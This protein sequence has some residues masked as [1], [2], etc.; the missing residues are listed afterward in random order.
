MRKGFVQFVAVAATALMAAG[1]NAQ[2]PPTARLDFAV[3]PPAPTPAVTADYVAPAHE[4]PPII[5][6]NAGMPTGTCTSCGLPRRH[7]L[8]PLPYSDE[9]GGN[10]YPGGMCCRCEAEG[11][12]AGLYCHFYN[13]FQ[14]PDPCY[15]PHWEAGANA[16]LFVDTVR[17]ATSIRLR[18]DRGINMILPDRS[19]F[20]WARIGTIKGPPLPETSVDYH[21]LSIYI[22]TAAER[23][24]AYTVIPYRS[25]VGE[26]NGGGAGFGDM[27]IGTKTLL[28]DTEYAQLTLQF[29][30]FIPQGKSTRG[31]GTG[32][33]SLEPSLLLSARLTPDT[34]FQGQ[35]AEWIPLGGDPEGSGAV[36]HYHMALNHVIARPLAD[37]QFIA[38]LEAQGYCFQDGTFTDPV[39]GAAVRSSGGQYWSVGPGFR[40]VLSERCDFGFGVMFAVTREHFANQ[41]YRSEFRLRF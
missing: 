6:V 34:Y 9:C 29:Q 12:L 26:V 31:L 27:I 8:P 1:T 19:E 14:C 18:W 11:G 39:T 5:P 35:I 21:E 7:E 30:T 40:W 22:E 15:E 25:V 20:F 23:F 37:S 3:T 16:A 4:R 24:S 13:A 32:H 17:P 38:T 10:C 33:V 2:E 36:L 41:L 28:I